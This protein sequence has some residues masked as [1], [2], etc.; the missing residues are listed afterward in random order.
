MRKGL[1]ANFNSEIFRKDHPMIIAANRHLASIK[2]ARLEYLAD[3]YAAGQVIA[4][5]Q[6]DG[7]FK[8][9]SAVSGGSF[10][11]VSV[12]FEDI[13]ANSATGDVL[14]RAVVG[15]EVYEGKLLD[16]NA[17][18]RTEMG[19]KSVVDASGTEILKF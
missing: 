5:D 15:G 12:L 19:A 8:K 6:S 2:A 13:R 1:D 9:F 16:L 18:A 17:S 7:L 10:D 14:A 3:G 11:T 4:R